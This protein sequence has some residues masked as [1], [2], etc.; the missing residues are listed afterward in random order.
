[1]DFSDCRYICLTT[2]YVL[3][4]ENGYWY[5]GYTCNLNARL[6]EHFGEQGRYSSIKWLEEHPAIDID[7]VIIGNKD[8]E[9]RITEE[10]MAKYGKDYVR[11]GKYCKRYYKYI[12]IHYDLKKIKL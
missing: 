6:A 8:D 5:V 2:V 4:L 9:D 7:K 11:G 10:Y 1:M 12:K 3:R